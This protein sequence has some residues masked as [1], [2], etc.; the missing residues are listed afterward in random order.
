MQD[1]PRNIHTKFG[2]NWSSSFRGEELC[3]IINDDD[4][5]RQRR[6]PS[7]GNSSHGL[8]PGELTRNTMSKL[9]KKKIPHATNELNV[10]HLLDYLLL[11]SSNRNYIPSCTSTYD[12][13][14]MCIRW[15]NFFSEQI[16]LKKKCSGD[17]A[18]KRG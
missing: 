3:I 18:K 4:G 16:M 8:R 9:T 15:C 7:E 6:T 2:F 1:A 13:Q 14:N 17:L 12:T 11:A 10:K 5:Q